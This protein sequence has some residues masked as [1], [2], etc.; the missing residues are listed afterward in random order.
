M[1]APER[2]VMNVLAHL[3]VNIVEYAQQR[4]VNRI[5]VGLWN[6]KSLFRPDCEF[7]AT[8]LRCRLSVLSHATDAQ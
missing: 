7:D 5:A 6:R 2:R 1:Q 4:P 8:Q 3:F